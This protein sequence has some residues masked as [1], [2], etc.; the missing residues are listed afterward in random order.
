[1]TFSLPAQ[2]ILPLQEHKVLWADTVYR[3]A[4]LKKD[5]NQLAEA[6][7]LYGKA[8]DGAGDLSM[9]RRYFLKS[10]SIIEP[11]GP[12]LQLARLYQRL[13]DNEIS[14]EHYKEAY[15]YAHHAL[16]IARQIGSDRFISA[17]SGSLEL[18]HGIYL[19]D[20]GKKNGL[21]QSRPDSVRYY[22]QLRLAA[23]NRQIKDTLNR[24]QDTLYRLQMKIGA[25]LNLWYNDHNM[26][27]IA[28]L[29]E[30]L[31]LAR[32]IKR[33][34]M[35][36]EILLRL[37]EIHLARK[38]FSLGE[39]YLREG[40]S[41]LEAGPFSNSFWWKHG[42]ARTYKNYYASIGDW[43]KALDYAEKAHA[44]EKTNYLQD[45][46]GAVSRLQVEYETEKK[47]LLLKAREEEIAL[48]NANA[49]VLTGFVLL[50][51]VLSVITL[52]ISVLF[53]RLYRKNRRISR[54][55]ELL[56]RE[57]NHRVKNNL[58]SI[59]SLLSLQSH[60]LT[61]SK[62]L[63]VINESRHRVESMAILHR[64]LY[65][66]ENA[67]YVFLPDFVEEVTENVLTSY[68][69]NAVA[70]ETG[71]EPIHL[72]A[73]KAVHLGLILNELITNACK[74]AFRSHPE[75]ALRISCR[76]VPENR[77]CLQVSDNGQRDQKDSPSAGFGMQLIEMEVEQLYGE[78]DFSYHNGTLFTM[79]F[80]E[81]APDP[82]KMIT[83]P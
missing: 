55:N 16:K 21:T 43:Q 63:E 58:Q 1:M 14:Q 67:G 73:D 6:W 60:E 38:E 41:L 5:T 27:S 20:K 71:V 46:D 24:P 44:F 48:K 33:K 40:E 77:I 30:A 62:A 19:S 8:H 7:Y 3:E 36:V 39:K 22:R 53:Y 65:K 26:A 81:K 70:L 61:D 4:V 54:Q 68:G 11:Q 15:K 29:H 12:S 78:S 34:T 28:Q 32:Q 52:G 50:L 64:K 59:S 79:T 51:G 82:A 76:A 10:L 72:A 25:G 66:G 18:I 31:L 49:R 56:V 47:Q 35:E 45:R 69:L 2:G 42:I 80:P 23:D 83:P 37:G 13:A 74:Y 75:P 17:A 9:A 57:Q